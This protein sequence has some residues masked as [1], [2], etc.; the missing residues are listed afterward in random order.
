MRI[1]ETSRPAE[2]AADP[3]RA[4]RLG[5]TGLREVTWQAP[6]FSE[7]LLPAASG[8]YHG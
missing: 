3:Q 7:P 1:A 6:S 2:R 5:L 8:V 4:L